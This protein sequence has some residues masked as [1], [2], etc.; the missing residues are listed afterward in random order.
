MCSW[1]EMSFTFEHKHHLLY[2]LHSY[3]A[4]LV[5]PFP[6]RM[7]GSKFPRC[8][9]LNYI[10]NVTWQVLVYFCESSVLFTSELNHN[11]EPASVAALH[12]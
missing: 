2:I 3:T 5:A 11:Q 12:Y 9:A 1:T 4:F 8:S 10:W 7:E 6:E